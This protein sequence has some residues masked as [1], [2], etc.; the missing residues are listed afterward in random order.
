[1]LKRVLGADMMVCTNSAASLCSVHHAYFSWKWLTRNWRN[2]FSE[3]PWKMYNW[4]SLYQQSNW[5]FTA[6]SLWS[7][8]S[9]CINISFT[10]F[11]KGILENDWWF[12]ANTK[13]QRSFSCHWATMQDYESP[14]RHCTIKSPTSSSQLIHPE[15]DVVINCRLLD[16]VWG[17]SILPI[18]HTLYSPNNVFLCP[19][20]GFFH[21]IFF[22]IRKLT[23]STFI[24]FTHHFLRHFAWPLSK[25]KELCE[26]MIYISSLVLIP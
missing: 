23:D 5:V 7:R 16:W 21:S 10:T 19:A 20:I 13:C 24:I 17:F 4:H 1:M 26:P 2:I 18:P 22:Q 3:S 25:E 9:C 6:L 11:T 14:R 12:P 8:A 15:P